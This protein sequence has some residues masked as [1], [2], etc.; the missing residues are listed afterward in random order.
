[1]DLMACMAFAWTLSIKHRTSRPAHARAALALQSSA[2]QHGLVE[3]VPGM[4]RGR[5]LALK[6]SAVKNHPG[7]GGSSVV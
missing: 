6:E 7:D 5:L 2:F 3:T 1:M 4:A